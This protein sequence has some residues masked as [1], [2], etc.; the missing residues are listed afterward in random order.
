V[1]LSEQDVEGNTEHNAGEHLD[2]EQC[3]AI[4]RTA[5]EPQRDIA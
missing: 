2:D 4:D 3:I 1:I 5:P